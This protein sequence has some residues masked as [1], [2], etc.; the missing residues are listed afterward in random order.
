M[1]F[2]IEQV[3]LFPADPAAAIELLTAMGLG[4]WA[5]DNVLAEGK[6]FGDRALSQGALAFNY[7]ASSDKALELE[8]LNYVVGDHWMSGREPSVSH[9]GMH[10][11]AEDLEKWRT[12]FA[13]RKIKVAQEVNTIRHTNPVIAGKRFYTYCI[14]DTRRILGV[15]VK[16]IV[17]RDVA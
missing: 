5:R 11:S 10:C 15:D 13:E 1:Q 6:V 3:A 7:E 2:K 4:A 16:F 9:L 14:F 17:R 8:V 12:F